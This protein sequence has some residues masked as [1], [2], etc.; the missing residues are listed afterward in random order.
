MLIQIVYVVA[1]LGMACGK[2]FIVEKNITAPAVNSSN[3]I[4]L[5]ML[6]AVHGGGSVRGMVVKQAF[7]QTARRNAVKMIIKKGSKRFMKVGRKV[8]RKVSNGAKKVGGKIKR[9]GK[10]FR[11]GVQKRTGKIMKKGQFSSLF[12]KLR[13]M[14]MMRLPALGNFAKFLANSVKK[15]VSFIMSMLVFGGALLLLLCRCICR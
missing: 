6:F 11:K 10:R 15:M 8:G 4:L 14:K 13:G 9:G 12:I 1:L 5:R 2:A 3:L 7:A